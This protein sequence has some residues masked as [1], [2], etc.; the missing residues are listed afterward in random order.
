MWF[1]SSE[2]TELLPFGAVRRRVSLSAGSD[3]QAVHEE[4]E[5]STDKICYVDTT[6]LT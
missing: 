2:L 3:G 4:L 1:W 6:D 5:H